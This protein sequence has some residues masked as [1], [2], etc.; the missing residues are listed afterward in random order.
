[1]IVILFVLDVL[2][3]VLLEFVFFFIVEFCLMVYICW[4]GVVKDVE[5]VILMV[6]KLGCLCLVVGLMGF[7]VSFGCF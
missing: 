7:V 5:D 4:V 6:V 1:M 2:V 3:C